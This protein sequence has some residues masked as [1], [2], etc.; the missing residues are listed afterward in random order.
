M[1]TELLILCFLPNIIRVT[2]CEE[3]EMDGTCG[4]TF[5]GK[6]EMKRPPERLS[7]RWGDGITLDLN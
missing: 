1:H 2:R 3:D 4:G 6:G 5:V 7:Y